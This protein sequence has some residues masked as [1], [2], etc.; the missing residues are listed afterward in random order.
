ML[1]LGP[2]TPPNC[3]G[4]PGKSSTVPRAPWPKTP[5][6][7]AP[8]NNPKDN[9]LYTPNPSFKTRKPDF[10][11]FLRHEIVIYW[12]SSLKSLQKKKWGN[13]ELELRVRKCWMCKGEEVKVLKVLNVKGRR[14]G[15]QQ[16]ER[17][18][19]HF[20]ELLQTRLRTNKSQRPFLTSCR[21]LDSKAVSG[22][23]LRQNLCNEHNRQK[24][25]WGLFKIARNFW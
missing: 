5:S 15:S 24:M 23:H 4:P 18:Q 25:S 16:T 22:R 13:R 20:W 17:N 8:L 2:Q 7:K 21:W 11:F 19:R 3:W 10:E 9:C 1:T 6:N 12:L 14:G